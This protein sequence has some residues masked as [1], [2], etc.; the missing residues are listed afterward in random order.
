MRLVYTI[1]LSITL[2]FSGIINARAGTGTP[3]KINPGAAQPMCEG[4]TATIGGSPTA[5]GGTAPYT[6]SWSPS[7][8]LSSI[9]NANPSVTITASTWYHLK[10]TDSTGTSLNDSVFV[11]YNFIVFA[12]A[13]KDTAFCLGSS[14]I[15]GKNNPGV[16]GL[17]YTWSPAAGL[18]NPSSPTPLASPTITTTYTLTVNE[19]PCSPKTE[20]VTV[21][22]HQVPKLSAGAYTII[23]EGDKATLHASGAKIYIWT[24]STT[25]TYNGTANPDAQPLSTTLY[26]VTATDK[27]GCNARDTVTVIVRRDDD[28]VLYNTFSPNA[29][30]SN[31]L[32]YIGNI[33]KYP[34]CKLDIYNRF[35]KLVYTRIGY[36]NDWDG[37]NFGDKLPEATYYY[38]LDLANGS[39]PYRG[40]V[41]IIR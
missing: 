39:K 11:Y 4:G 14:A 29:D 20:Q 9:T 2:V 12:H 16:S 3:L 19:S 23:N 28:I 17:T 34:N 26:T 13:G 8:G 25:I 41:T 40:S 21:T 18:S 5:Q 24:P 6:Y 32:F 7:A 1:L 30:G 22:V 37:T 10:V 15:I 27:Y 38:I 31:D 35:G 33:E 36:A